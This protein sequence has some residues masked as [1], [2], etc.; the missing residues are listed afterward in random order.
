M[1]QRGRQR[2]AA[3]LLVAALLGIMGLCLAPP[4]FAR[5]FS[6]EPLPPGLLGWLP[7]FGSLGLALLLFRLRRSTPAPPSDA[8]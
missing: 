2:V 6:L 8:S 5:L 3:A 4:V 7:C 1:S